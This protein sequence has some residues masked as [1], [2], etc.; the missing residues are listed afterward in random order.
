M[1]DVI[2]NLIKDK[3][4]LILGFGMEGQST[5][6]LLKDIGLYSKIGIADKKPPLNIPECTM[7]SDANYLDCIDDYDITFKSPGVIL[8]KAYT[9]YKSVFT[10]QT[11]LFLQVYN[12]QVIGVTGT[13]GKSTVSSLLYHVLSWKNIPCILAGN[14]GKPVFDII[15]DIDVKTIVVLELSCH[16]LDKCAYSPALSV[17]LNIYQ[18]HLDY[19]GTFENYARTKKNIY[20]HQHPLDVLYCNPDTI[21]FP[22]EHIARTVVVKSDIL[23]FESP[24]SVF[25]TKLP[26][27]HNIENAAFV[28]CIAKTF[29]LTDSDFAE[30]IKSFTP[31]RHRLELIGNKDG[32]DYYDDSISTTAESAISAVESIQ[33]ASTILL[34]GMDRGIDYT[35]L[36]EYLCTCKLLNVICMYESGKRIFDMLESCVNKKPMIT[37]CD[38]LTEAVRAAEKVT[39]S[40]TACLLSP[41]SASYSDFKD[42]RERSEKFKSLVF[43]EV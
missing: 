43:D 36:V 33:N 32:V 28:Y 19:Y 6:K 42:F 20:L 13:K 10:S 7:H 26:G 12:R 18:D 40:G 25:G 2:S 39:P 4:V 5:Y 37:Y 38:N 11:E 24:E 30:S 21:P 17:L 34:G 29:G 1:V 8:P 9:E 27:K 15:K 41:A 31:L 3:S 23:P 16:Q 14:I 22:E 35:G